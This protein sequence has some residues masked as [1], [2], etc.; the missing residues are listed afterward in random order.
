MRIGMRNG[1]RRVEA[2]GAAPWLRDRPMR[3]AIRWGLD[4][5]LSPLFRSWAPIDG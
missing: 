1:M 2:V 5:A 3:R 4:G